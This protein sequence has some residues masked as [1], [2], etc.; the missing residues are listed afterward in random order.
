MADDYDPSEKADERPLS[1]EEVRRITAGLS[2]REP[3]PAD[4]RRLERAVRGSDE[5]RRAYV[6]M[7]QTHAALLT[8][9]TQNGQGMPQPP[10]PA[11]DVRSGG[12]LPRG[13]W[14]RLGEP[15]YL[16]LAAL[17]LAATLL[18]A[19][20]PSAWWSVAGSPVAGHAES[21]RQ[22]T[23]GPTNQP[24]VVAQV[25]KASDD[26]RLLIDGSIVENSG[27]VELHS[28]AEVCL[29]TGAIHVQFSSGVQ[30]AFLAPAV[31]RPRSPMSIE[32]IEGHLTADV[33]EDGS[34]FT[35][36]T[37]DAEVVDLGT[38]FGVSVSS[39]RGTEVVVF[40][41]EVEVNAP[42][43]AES[44]DVHFASQRVET[45]EGV[46]IG[47]HAKPTPLTSFTCD[48]YVLPEEL[49]SGPIS[50]AGKV[51][52]SVSDNLKRGEHATYCYEIIN[53]GMRED[54]IAFADRGYHQWNGLS[55]LGMPRYLKG[56]DYV[57]GFSNLK[58][59][60]DYQMHVELSQPANLYVFWDDRLVVPSWL[61]RKFEPTG[62]KIGLDEGPHVDERHRVLQRK[63]PGLGPGSSIDQTFSIWKRV[64]EEPSTITC[65]YNSQNRGHVQ[66]YGVAATPL[67]TPSTG[68][69]I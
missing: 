67:E 38:V 54:A 10:L 63:F 34:G 21:P 39:V 60:E 41:G 56:A 37:A 15:K 69:G 29:I 35:V 59:D 46:E 31:F 27:V 50:K 36:E 62:D 6:S 64:V 9:T 26:C 8:Q 44:V 14:S 12:H 7:R 33:G 5:A 51:I 40:D 61:S 1:P 16:A 22:L 65:G 24:E 30:S 43:H 55:E 66:M 20:T 19:L 28:D 45:G 68:P 49:F 17:A 11:G 13:R 32:M 25:T 48:D 2:D 4:F 53:G 47:S 52:A 18:L 58:H 3:T 42:K 23:E 57:I